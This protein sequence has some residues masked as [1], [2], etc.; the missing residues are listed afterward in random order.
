MGG[1][2]YNE[3]LN[4]SKAAGDSTAPGVPRKKKEKSAKDRATHPT[5]LSRHRNGNRWQ[6]RSGYPIPRQVELGDDEIAF[7]IKIG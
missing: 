2:L 6:G 4:S 7:G 5:C 1:G 3:M